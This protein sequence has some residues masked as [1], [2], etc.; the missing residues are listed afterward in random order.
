MSDEDLVES[1]LG[2]VVMLGDTPTPQEVLLG[3]QVAQQIASREI[4]D[5]QRGT[6]SSGHALG[7]TSS[8]VVCECGESFGGES[9]GTAISRWLDHSEAAAHQHI[10]EG[11]ESA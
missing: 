1:V 5:Y 2:E 11:G 6:P 7:N 4:G 9:E 10:A 3:E 8:T